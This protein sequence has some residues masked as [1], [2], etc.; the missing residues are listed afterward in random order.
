MEHLTPKDRQRMA[1]AVEVASI[2][3]RELAESGHVVR[4]HIVLPAVSLI[5]AAADPACLP[6]LA[7]RDEPH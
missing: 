2:V 7:Q 6:D 1:V 5:P 3:K 4:V